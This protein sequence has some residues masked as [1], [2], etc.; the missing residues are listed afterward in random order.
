LQPWA[1]ALTTI[2]SEIA[3]SW[4]GIP[5]SLEYGPPEE[6]VRW[7]LGTF[8]PDRVAVVTALQ[9]EGVAVADMAIAI[10]PDV[11][12]VTIDT[13]RLPEETHAYIDAL[14]DHF[15]R[16][17]EVVL[18]DPGPIEQFVADHGEN[19]FY[20]APE[21]RLECCHHRKVSPLEGIL[22]GLDCWLVGLRRSQSSSRA[23]V[24]RAEPDPNHPGVIRVSPVASWDQ[25][26]AETYLKERGIPVHPLYD[27]GY[28]S[29]GCAPCTRA[30]P[31]GQDVRAGRWWWETGIDK[32]CGI[33]GSPV[34][35]PGENGHTQKTVPVDNVYPLKGSRRAP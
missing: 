4:D 29:I 6:A 20:E 14:R 35:V 16:A 26:D 9:A 15:G 22:A 31:A 23:A 32:E 24:R 7:A 13:G 12:I 11:R 30:V 18:P 10:D 34:L 17:I 3:Q 27:R 28:L 25:H 5:E 19:A 2:L 33:H 8:E 21:L 1:G